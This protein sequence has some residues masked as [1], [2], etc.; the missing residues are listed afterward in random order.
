MKAIFFTA[1]FIATTTFAIHAMAEAKRNFQAWESPPFVIGKGK[2][3]S[4]AMKDVMDE[5]CKR[6]HFDNCKLI[7]GGWKR[8]QVLAKEKG[9]AFALAPIGYRDDRAKWMYYSDPVFATSYA[10]FTKNS[11]NLSFT[12]PS[13]LNGYTLATFG[14]SNTSKKLEKL[15]DNVTNSTIEIEPALK[16]A[17]RKMKGNRYAEKSAVYGNADMIRYMIRTNDDYKGIREAGVQKHLKY[18][19]GFPK[20]RV[21]NAEFE[22]LNSAIKNMKADGTLK[23]ILDNYDL[24]LPE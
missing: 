17:L 5:A 14:P 15:A 24:T 20:N 23:S 1:A 12:Q 9:Q 13:D 4:G 3:T 16:I 8:A 21:G 2:N 19:I 22:S 10:L 11:D 18:Y 6:A 7:E